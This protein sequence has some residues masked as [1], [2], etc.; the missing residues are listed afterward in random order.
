MTM[1]SFSRRAFV[2]G[3][4]ALSA[5]TLEAQNSAPLTANQVIERIRQNVGVPWRAQTVDNIVLGDGAVPVK[6]IATTMMATFD[7]VK[8]CVESGLNLI[9]SHET[10]V[11]MHQDDVKP[12][13]NNPTYLAKKEY[14]E[15]NRA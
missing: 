1:D 11:Y 13:E 6:G 12:L 15:K 9:V 4:L 7:V 5:Q 3:G 2:G 10:P 8:R 14:C